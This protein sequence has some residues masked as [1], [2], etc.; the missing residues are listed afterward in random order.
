VAEIEAIVE[1]DGVGNDVRWESMAF[2][3]IYRL[4]VPS[5]LICLG[6][7]SLTYIMLFA[8]SR[9]YLLCLLFIVICTY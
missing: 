3:S 9:L 5:L 4:I 1:P 7:T 8:Y 2:I 6:N